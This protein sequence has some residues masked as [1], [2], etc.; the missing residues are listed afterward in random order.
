MRESGGAYDAHAQASHRD[1]TDTHHSTHKQDRQ[2]SVLGD[3]SDYSGVCSV[4]RP[5]NPAATSQKKNDFLCT[6]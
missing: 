1:T 4:R 6:L 3:H 2:S 5:T